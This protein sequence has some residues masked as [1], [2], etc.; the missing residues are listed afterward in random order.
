[1]LLR[2]TC[3]P[4]L[5]GYCSAWR[6]KLCFHILTRWQCG[7]W[8]GKKSALHVRQAESHYDL[9][10]R[11][12]WHTESHAPFTAE[13]WPNF[14]FIAL[15][16]HV[17]C[18]EKPI[19]YFSVLDFCCCCHHYTLIN[20]KAQLNLVPPLNN[21]LL[22]QLLGDASLMWKIQFNPAQFSASWDFCAL[23]RSIPP[24]N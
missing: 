11:S 20:G 5:S 23:A 24:L 14:H 21:L 7:S 8:R 17:V 12:L 6:L 1:M 9:L 16:C 3:T 4:E 10:L 13:S 15:Y 18:M 22:E 19:L 2:P